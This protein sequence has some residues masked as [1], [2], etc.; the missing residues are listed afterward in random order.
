MVWI[1]S[2]T[3]PFCWSL[4]R[5]DVFFLMPCSFK[6]YRNSLDINSSPFFHQNTLIT[7]S[8][9]ISTSVL[10]SLNFSNHSS[11]VFKVYTHT[12]LK[13][14]QWR[15]QSTLYH[16]RMWSSWSLTH[17]NA[18]STKTWLHTP[19]PPSPLFAFNASFINQRQC[20]TNHFTKIHATYNI[21]KC[22]KTLHIQVSKPIMPKLKCLLFC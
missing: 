22:M 18:Q 21:L 4:Y 13:N 6:S 19:P 15:S 8:N 7:Y 2:F 11:L 17:P 16:P 3:T 10:H 9:C 1:A 5:V 12:F 14:H 20:R